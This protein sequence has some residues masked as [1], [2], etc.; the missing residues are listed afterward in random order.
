MQSGDGKKGILSLPFVHGAGYIKLK[1]VPIFATKTDILEFLGEFRPRSSEHIHYPQGD[2]GGTGEAFV[3]LESNL[4]AFQTVAS[5]NGKLMMLDKVEVMYETYDPPA[6]AEQ[7][8]G[9][10][11]MQALGQQEMRIDKSDGKPYTLQS[12]VAVY[13]GTK[14]WDSSVRWHPPQI[15]AQKEMPVVEKR[16]DITDGKP[17][18]KQDFID[19]YGGTREWDSSMPWQGSLKASG[20]SGR[21]DS[22]ASTP[23]A[24]IPGTYQVLKPQPKSQPISQAD[25][26][27]QSKQQSVE[28][29]AQGSLLSALDKITEARKKEAQP[30]PDTGLDKSPSDARA[31]SQGSVQDEVSKILGKMMAD[32]KVTTP[33]P[34]AFGKQQDRLRDRSRSRNKGNKAPSTSSGKT[35]KKKEEV[36]PDLDDFLMFDKDE[37]VKQVKDWRKS[38][39]KG[40]LQWLAWVDKKGKN[41]KKDPA[42]YDAAFLN[43]FMNAARAELSNKITAAAPKKEESEIQSA[44]SNRELRMKGEQADPVKESLV[45]QVKNMQHDPI[46][47]QRWQDHCNKY[48]TSNQY[49]FGSFDPW[50]HGLGSLQAFLEGAAS[51]LEEANRSSALSTSAYIGTGARTVA[52]QAQR[53]AVTA[54]PWR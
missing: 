9:Q 44:Y 10:R 13:G 30:V 34:Q 18:T 38:T 51:Q 36:V 52:A 24:C 37:L 54:L 35:D 16:I 32:D 8:N 42:F 45:M 47:K 33:T 7:G 1:G 22:P 40:K 23:D 12:F 11:L 39:E 27:P 15:E 53:A 21:S 19:Q 17:Y 48:A 29:I 14:E 26:P 6:G 2:G 31:P 49:C 4:K 28:P 43:D 5:K 50:A 20:S 25:P 3:M 46:M 41:G